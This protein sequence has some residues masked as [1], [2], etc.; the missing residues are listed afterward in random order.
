MVTKEEAR[1]LLSKYEGKLTDC[2]FNGWS[3]YFEYDSQLKL[4]HRART[5]ANIVYDHIVENAKKEFE[6]ENGVSHFIARGI[7]LLKVEDKLIIRFKMLDNAKRPKNVKTRHNQ[8]FF[9]QLDLPNIPA[10]TRL[11]VGYEL[12]KYETSIKS[13]SVICPNGE[14]NEWVY[15]L[16]NTRQTTLH[17]LPISG[18]IYNE[19]DQIR[20]K[21]T[22]ERKAKYDKEA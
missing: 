4:V 19:P 22:K 12:N 5:R 7:F 3:D 9:Q 8:E 11:V 20:I 13:I 21:E 1:E 14:N 6:D 15:D 10:A 2:V 16:T 18:D 17:E